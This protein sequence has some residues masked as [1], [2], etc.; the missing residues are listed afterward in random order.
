MPI[1]IEIKTNPIATLAIINK[2]R[3][4]LIPNAAMNIAR[5]ESRK[6]AA[7]TYFQSNSGCATAYT[8]GNTIVA[9]LAMRPIKLQIARRESNDGFALTNFHQPPI[10]VTNTVPRS[11]INIPSGMSS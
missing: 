9:E 6:H 3:T 11:P 1:G 2:R 5:T 4:W 7:K 10:F 8:I